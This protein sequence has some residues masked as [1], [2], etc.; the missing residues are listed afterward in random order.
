[1][2]GWLLVERL[3]DGHATSLGAASGIVAGLVAITP[4][5]G[6]LTPIT[7]LIVGLIGG[8]I[9]AWG[10]GLKYRYGFDD[11]LDVVGVHLLAGL[12]GTIAIGFF[13]HDSGLFSGG[14]SDGLKLL[15][16]QA[17]IALFAMVFAA[18]ISL[19]IGYAL[20]RTMG[21]RVDAEAEHMGID[22]N[23]HGESAYDAVGPE[24]R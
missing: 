4:A 19:V 23:Q 10:V 9:A 18:A 22:S 8:A 13:H 5:A 15:V 7:S 20:R 2:L 1:M 16:V 17:V 6:A 3:R 12:W 21:W 11:T 14:G 24:I